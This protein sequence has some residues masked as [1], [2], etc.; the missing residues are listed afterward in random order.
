MSQKPS[1]ESQIIRQESTLGEYAAS[2]KYTIER[3]ENE[4]WIERIWKKDATLWKTDEAHR[5]IIGN[6]LG[7]VAVVDLLSDHAD[8]LAAF[9]DEVR[10]DG[11]TH[12]ML[13]GMG[14]SSL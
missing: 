7:W 9:G 14:G 1:G 6:A 3:A 12:V 10:D 8:E 5:K 13:L 4:R 11:F 2:V